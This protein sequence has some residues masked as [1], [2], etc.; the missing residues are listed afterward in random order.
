MFPPILASVCLSGLLLLHPMPSKPRRSPRCAEPPPRG[1]GDG[2]P[3]QLVVLLR[4]GESLAQARQGSRKD[5]ALLDCG[6]S[7][8]GRAQARAVDASAFPPAELVVSSPLARALLT[9][10]TVRFGERPPAAIVVHPALREL[11]SGIPENRPRPVAEQLRAEPALAGAPIDFG[12]LPP[13][14]PSEEDAAARGAAAN[15]P[16][17]LAAALAWLRARPERVVWV[18]CHHN[19]IQALVAANPA[20]ARL[21][22]VP[23]CVPV[24]CALRD[25]A[26]GAELEVLRDAAAW[27]P[28][29]PAGAAPAGA[30]AVDAPAV[31]APAASPTSAT[32]RRRRKGRTTELRRPEV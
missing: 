17:R 21:E 10:S 20:N 5:P 3:P 7:P 1:A 12:L 14:W 16:E 4:H 27:A 29:A 2:R 32:R 11:G 24:A 31:D 30:A 23:N 26:R 22:R 25:G 19:V 15:G 8:R 28:R 13:S 9:A 18:V 6:L